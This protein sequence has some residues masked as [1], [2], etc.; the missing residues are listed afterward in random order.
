M[1]RSLLYASL[2]AI[3][4]LVVIVG[5]AQAKQNPAEPAA[6]PLQ[7]EVSAESML[8]NLTVPFLD[9]WL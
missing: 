3:L 6:P 4:A 9:E 5:T 2:I 1:R 7:E 8:E